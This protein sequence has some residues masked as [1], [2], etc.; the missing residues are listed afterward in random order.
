MANTHGSGRATGSGNHVG[1]RRFW[2][3]R[4]SAYLPFEEVRGAGNLR[5]MRQCKTAAVVSAAMRTESYEWGFF[6]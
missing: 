2:L 1:A 5:A 6:R 3:T 4:S